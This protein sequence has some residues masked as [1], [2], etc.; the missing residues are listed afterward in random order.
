MARGGVSVELILVPENDKRSRQVLQANWMDRG[1]WEGSRVAFFDNCIVHADAPI[2][3]QANLS[4]EAIANPVTSAKKA[5]YLSAAEE[6]RVSFTSLL[7][8][9]TE[10]VLHREYAAYPKRLA[11]RLAN[12]WQ[13]PFSVTMVWVQVRTQFAVFRS[14][15]LRLRGTCRGICGLGLQDGAAI[16][17]GY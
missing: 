7:V 4:W 8:C 16:R 15:D 10:E 13:K 12:K 3:V 17:V 9:Y 6:L 14:V 2:Y 1:I 11:C 5:K